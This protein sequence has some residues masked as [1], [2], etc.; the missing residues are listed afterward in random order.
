MFHDEI[1][2]GFFAIYADAEYGD[3]MFFE[4][5]DVVAETTGF[6]DTAGGL[7]FGVKIDNQLLSLKIGQL[8]RLSILVIEFELRCFISNT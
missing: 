2:V 6:F 8:D 5:L 1:L 3:L 4:S 7:V